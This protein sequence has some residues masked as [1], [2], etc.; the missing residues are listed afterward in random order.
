MLGSSIIRIFR[1]EDKNLKRSAN[2]RC[3]LLCLLVKKEF[4][5]SSEA[6]NGNPCML[7]QC[8]QL[9]MIKDLPLDSWLASFVVPYINFLLNDGFVVWC[10]LFKTAALGNSLPLLIYDFSGEK[11]SDLDWEGTLHSPPL[12]DVEV[13]WKCMFF[14]I[15]VWHDTFWSWNIHTGTRHWAITVP[16]FRAKILRRVLFFLYSSNIQ[17]YLL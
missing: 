13:D 11:H 15:L 16:L 17:I 6:K 5:L 4:I 8:L 9:Y 1:T 2:Q 3:L 7:C 14:S 10:F 12:W